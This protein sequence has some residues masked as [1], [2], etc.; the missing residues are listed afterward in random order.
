MVKTAGHILKS[1]DVKFE[2]CCHLDIGTGQ[3]AAGQVKRTSTAS[4]A[5]QVC[6]VESHAQFAV[7]E[8]TCSCGTKTLVRCEYAD[9]GSA[10]QG[11]NQT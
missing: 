1:D 7:I 2:G 4:T 3:T 11:P 9:V 6:V 5:P 8:V 10:D